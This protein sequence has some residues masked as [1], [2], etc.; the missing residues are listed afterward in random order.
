MSAYDLSKHLLH[1]N[2][3][4]EY[5]LRN[6]SQVKPL[7]TF[8]RANGAEPVSFA[9]MSRHDPGDLELL[10]AGVLPLVPPTAERAARIFPPM[11]RKLDVVAAVYISRAVRV[12]E[13]EEP[14][15]LVMQWN[16]H[17]ETR[18]EVTW[19]RFL[20]DD[21]SVSAPVDLTDTGLVGVDWIKAAL[22]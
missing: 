6:V 1:A 7:V 5:S 8:V 15:N 22:S 18:T 10:R 21:G 3:V 2:D 13:G 12:R 17:C 14:Q 16:Y 4:W 19:C 9:V 11:L 20:N